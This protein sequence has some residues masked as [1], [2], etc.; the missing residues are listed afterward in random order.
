M[1]LKLV[2]VVSDTSARGFDTPRFHFILFLFFI[3]IQ[4]P[5][6]NNYIRAQELRVIDASGANIGVQPLAKALE[7]AHEAGLDLIEVAP[8]AQP[9]VARIMD[10]G[11][12]LYQK[13]KEARESAKKQKTVDIKSVRIGFNSSKHDMELK[14]EQAVEFLEESGR[15]KIDMILRG[16]AKYMDKNFIRERVQVFLNLIT[17]PYTTAGDIRPGPRGISLIIEHHGEN[18]QSG[19]KTP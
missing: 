11:K 3:S 13:E 15:V 7:L 14:A 12:Y 19:N 4:K 16:R 5:R 17:V 8:N 1:P 6:I 2:N 9:P 10:Y 18:K